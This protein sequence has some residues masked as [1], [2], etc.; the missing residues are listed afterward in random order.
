LRTGS[1]SHAGQTHDQRKGSNNGRLAR[2]LKN[3]IM[4]SIHCHSFSQMNQPG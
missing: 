1:S 2:Q 3:K 4:R